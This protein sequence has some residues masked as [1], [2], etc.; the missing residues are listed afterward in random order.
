MLKLV[1]AFSVRCGPDVVFTAVVKDE[2]GIL[3]EGLRR[4]VQVGWL[5]G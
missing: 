1:G 2:L 4:L 5:E 3:D